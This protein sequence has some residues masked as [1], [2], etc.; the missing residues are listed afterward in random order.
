MTDEITLVCFF[1]ILQAAHK[2]LVYIITSQQQMKVIQKASKRF[3]IN[4]SGDVTTN[5]TYMFACLAAT[6]YY[7]NM[8]HM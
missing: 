5:M 6:H 8:Y 4:G 1:A 2:L 3:L 7:V